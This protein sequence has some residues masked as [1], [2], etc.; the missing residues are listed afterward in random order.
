MS[1]INLITRPFIVG[2]VSLFLVSCSNP[3]LEFWRQVPLQLTR[4]SQQESY[5]QKFLISTPEIDK[6]EN[7]NQKNYERDARMD[8]IF[9]HMLGRENWQY[10]KNQYGVHEVRDELLHGEIVIK[11]MLSFIAYYDNMYKGK[12]S[13]PDH[14]ILEGSGR[15]F[16]VRKN[17]DAILMSGDFKVRPQRYSLE[18][19][20]TG[21]IPMDVNLFVTRIPG[22][23]TFYKETVLHYDINIDLS[24]KADDVYSLD[25]NSA[26]PVYLTINGKN[27]LIGSLKFDGKDRHVKLFDL[28]GRKF[29]KKNYKLSSMEQSQIETEN[30]M[31]KNKRCISDR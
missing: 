23:T 28:S 9:N 14:V 22:E 10:L 27:E 26:Q 8:K 16:A 29:I 18:V 13:D 12:P 21:C 2:C 7:R 3:A 11:G 6:I 24:N 20:D 1:Y 5:E 19:M 17:G 31:D 15:F 25:Y 30:A 4:I